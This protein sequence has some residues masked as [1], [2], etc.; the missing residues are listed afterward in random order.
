MIDIAS[1][2]LAGFQD[3]LVSA[4]GD[5]LGWIIG[6]MILILLLILI[7]W[8]IQ[9]RERIIRESGW[10][11]PN[12]VDVSVILLLTVSQYVVYTSLLDFPST[13][14]WGLAIFWALTLR[15]H[16]LVLE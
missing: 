4:F 13:A 6:H 2:I 7:L 1:L 9:N 5:S 10:G 15:W 12:L 8:I 16:V 14:S 3:N 11:Y